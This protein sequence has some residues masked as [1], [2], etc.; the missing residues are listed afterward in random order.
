MSRK[1]A[2]LAAIAALL[3]CAGPASARTLVGEITETE[4]GQDLVDPMGL[5]VDSTDHL[6]VTTHY[7]EGSEV[8]KY[9]PTGTWEAE[10]NPLPW[11][12]SSWVESIAFDEAAEEV[13]AAE[14]YKALL[15][16]L[17]PADASFDGTELD[18]L[19]DREPGGETE[20]CFIRVAADNSG[21]PYDGALYVF[22]SEGKTSS[23][24][25]ILRIDSEGNPVAFTEGSSAGS[26]ELSGADTP[27][28]HFI[29]PHGGSGA[30]IAIDGVGHIWVATNPGPKAYLHEFGPTG[31]HLRTVSGMSPLQ[32]YGEVNALAFDPTIGTIVASD[33]NVNKIHEFTPSG[34]FIGDTVISG[35]GSP[36][37]VAVDSTG[38]LYVSNLGTGLSRFIGTFGPAGPPA[39]KHPL[40]VEVAGPG[41]V[42]GA[43]IACEEGASDPAA[44]EEEF[45][46][47]T[48]VPLLLHP[49]AGYQLGSWTAV[50]GDAGSCTGL[51][52]E[53]GALDEAT[54]V[55]ATFAPI[56]PPIDGGG[57]PGGGQ[58]PPPVV[59]A[60]LRIG[61]VNWVPS[62]LKLAVSG[63]IAKAASGVVK[64]KATARPG[65]RLVVVN[66]RARIRNGHWRARLPLLW[67][68]R[69]PGARVRVTARFEGSAGVEGDRAKRRLK[70]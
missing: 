46:E 69:H 7:L 60:R 23:S 30:A 66:R 35:G 58:Q 56:P 47:G 28:G 43:G 29:G 2:F 21:G 32:G 41:E 20:C 61:R 4:P 18:P 38:K 67:A 51:Y 55:R 62:R 64:V 14:S 25:T 8:H 1:L 3:I 50:E 57:E 34:V 39:P 27:F 44:C 42:A 65:G 37:G 24:G 11:L 9:R 49:A 31:R 5:A 26:N 45:V 22:S 6:W 19:G 10:T 12:M 15:W 68:R 59:P 63:T 16:G 33:S 17:D 54:K 70:L 48:E 53:T 36:N 40:E 52:C 13:F